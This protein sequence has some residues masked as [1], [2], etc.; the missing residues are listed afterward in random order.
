MDL[1]EGPIWSLAWDLMRLFCGHILEVRAG[2]SQVLKDFPLYKSGVGHSHEE[3]TS[4]GGGPRRGGTPLTPSFSEEKT[5][6]Q[7]GQHIW[8]H[9]S[10][11]WVFMLPFA[12]VLAALLL[13]CTAFQRSPVAELDCF[14][15]QGLSPSLTHS[16]S[17]FSQLIVVPFPPVNQTPSTAREMTSS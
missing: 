13:F 10:R 4:R 2:R 5:E 6:V 16:I 17:S 12:L 8:G 15:G 3:P 7:E 1:L 9:V 14:S 11:T